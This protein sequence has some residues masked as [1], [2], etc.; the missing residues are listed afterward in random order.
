MMQ[1]SCSIYDLL[2]EYTKPDLL[3]D[4]AC[5]KCSMLATLEKYKSQRDRLAGLVVP[6]SSNP[7][8]PSSTNTNPFDLPATTTKGGG[9]T[10]MTTSRKDRLKKVGKLVEKVQSVVDAGDYEKPLEIE[11]GG[12]I[13]VEK[14]GTAAGKSVNL[15][16][17]R[18]I[19]L[20]SLS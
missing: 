11:S 14:V 4:Y 20:L 2:G 16:R 5:R 3:S 12:A 15:A 7:T 17:V 13:K 19:I 8:P 9:D 10:K 6:P 18:S 1:S